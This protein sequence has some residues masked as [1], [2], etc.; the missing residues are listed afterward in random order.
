MLSDVELL[1]PAWLLLLP[2]AI[3]VA[4]RWGEM[5]Q[6]LFAPMPSISVRHPLA[7]RLHN[8]SVE[9]AAP[10]LHVR[11]VVGLSLVL[12][13]FAMAQPVRL[14]APLNDETLPV[15]LVIMVDTSVTMN[16]KD[17]TVEGQAV[18]RLTIAKIIA[19][20]LLNEFEGRK[21]AVV[22]LGQPSA[23]WL[24][25]TA[26]IELAQHLL[27]RIRLSLGG[28]YAGLGDGLVE[29]AEQ[30]ADEADPMT[31]RMVLLLT[32]GVLPSGS[33]SPIEGGR[34]L[35]QSGMKLM[36]L[37]V[38]AMSERAAEHVAGQ[39]SMQ[40]IYEPLDMQ[41]LNDIVQSSGGKA[42]HA[43]TV[44]QAVAELQR[45]IRMMGTEVKQVTETD[46]RQIPLYP[47]L[48]TPALLLLLG[49]PLMAMRPRPV[50]GHD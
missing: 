18:D 19:E 27:G 15:D 12:M 8:V 38:G 3:F 47:W 2:L 37:G 13:L 42:L 35:A 9:H 6:S 34:R 39:G 50:G 14:G 20:R 48:L 22:V 40:L 33:V 46:R 30:F 49:L 16:L 21:V 11:I 7:D 25:L 36:A 1:S 44:E 4:Q 43:E 29:V 23:I 41:L 5:V 28:R 31:G 26:E 32:D 45:Q 10:A 24:P 17:Y